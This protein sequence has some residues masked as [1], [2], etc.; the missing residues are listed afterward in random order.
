MSTQVVI[1]CPVLQGNVKHW[2]GELEGRGRVGKQ[3][4]GMGGGKARQVVKGGVLAV[5]V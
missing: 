3:A 1:L 2:E 5:I 4:N